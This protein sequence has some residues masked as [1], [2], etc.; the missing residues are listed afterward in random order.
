MI[1]VLVTTWM[2][3]PEG[4]KETS[5]HRS[6]PG[7]TR[8]PGAA[9]PWCCRNSW[10]PFSVNEKGSCLQ[11][12]L[13][14]SGVSKASSPRPKQTLPFGK[15]TWWL[16]LDKKWAPSHDQPLT[17]ELP[18]G[19]ETFPP[20]HHLEVGQPREAAQ[21]LLPSEWTQPH[22]DSG[23]LYFQGHTVNMDFL[24][25]VQE[26]LVLMILRQLIVSVAY[27]WYHQSNCIALVHLP[28]DSRC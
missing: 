24:F 10:P 9:A 25:F 3:S 21:T 11:V 27:R 1:E 14:A 8:A 17:R 18:D 7:T 2:D 15:R 22:T 12:G 26:F 23:F 28:S 4:R 6:R 13:T 16:S 20:H 19:N 5:G